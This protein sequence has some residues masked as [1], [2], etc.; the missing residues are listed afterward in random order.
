MT[1]D[2]VVFGFHREFCTYLI[3]PTTC[4]L[5]YLWASHSSQNGQWELCLTHFPSA[6]VPVTE[7]QLTYICMPFGSFILRTFTACSADLIL[8]E[9]CTLLCKRTRNGFTLSLYFYAGSSHFSLSHSHR[10][11]IRD[12]ICFLDHGCYLNK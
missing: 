9:L 11:R 7:L 12:P 8:G 5:T 2:F 1:F 4:C 3:P 6:D 10:L